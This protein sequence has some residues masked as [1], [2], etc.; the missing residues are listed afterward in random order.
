MKGIIPPVV[1]LLDESGQIDM[2]KN[3][4]AIDKLISHGVH[5]VVLLGSSGEFPHFSLEEKQQYLKQIIPY[6]DNRIPVLVGTGGTV[7]EE[8]IELSKF[9]QE[10][11]AEGVLVVNPYYWNLSDE[12]M[13]TYFYEVAG[14]LSIDLY[15]YNIPQLTGQE[16][17]VEVVK[18]LAENIQNI[19]GIKETVASM[20]RIRTVIDEVANKV[21]NFH[22]YSAFDEHLLDAQLYGASGS[23]NG[24]SV[25]LPEISLN[26]YEAI[27]NEDFTEVKRHHIL[28][29][30]LMEIYS[31]HPSFY[32]TMKLA[33]HERWF[34]NQ[35]IG[36]RKPFINSEAHLSDTIKSIISEYAGNE[37]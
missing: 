8:T 26:L 33:V 11:G 28:I 21:N 17:P 25:F 24:S 35:A 10:L 27:Q 9:V 16:I 13:Y 29:C 6:I 2:E 15:L 30:K 18:Q 1:T 3:K 19:R 37:D 22:V 5:G 31:L 14:S 4:R 23:I 34:V 32:L 7:M 20:T 12:Q 36:Y